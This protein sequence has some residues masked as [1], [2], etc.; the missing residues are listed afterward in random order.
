[1]NFASFIILLFLLLV[2][3]CGPW[4]SVQHSVPAGEH[5]THDVQTTEIQ[6]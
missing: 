4:I 2:Q 3:H 6:I 5:D 1:M